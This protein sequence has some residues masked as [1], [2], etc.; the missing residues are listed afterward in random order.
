M[1][2]APPSSSGG[3]LR[4]VTSLFALPLVI[5]RSTHY[6]RLGVAPEATADEIRVASAKLDADLRARGASAE[7]LAEAHAINLENGRVRAAYD[8]D[9]PPLSLLRLE[10]T[11][12]PVFDDK[13]TCLAVL[14]REL[15]EFLRDAGEIVYHPVDITRT[16]FTADFTPTPLIDAP[17]PD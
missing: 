10:P 7:K 14:R 16:D 4:E 1:S 12:H 3:E 5:P 2:E 8:A 15:E 9:H 11:G 13:A 6:A 17:E